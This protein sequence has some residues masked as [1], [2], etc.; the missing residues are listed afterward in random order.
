MACCGRVNSAIRLTSCPPESDYADDRYAS[1]RLPGADAGRRTLLAAPAEATPLTAS[2]IMANY[3]LVTSG[4]VSTNSDIEGSAVIGGNLSSATLFNNATASR[5][6]VLY[7]YGANQS[8]TNVNNGGAVHWQQPRPFQPERLDRDPGR[9]C[10]CAV[11]IY[12][13]R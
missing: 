9:L 5:G 3:N 7:L 1:F 10:L 13:R 2:Q 11:R 4:N 12:S 6:P 8:N